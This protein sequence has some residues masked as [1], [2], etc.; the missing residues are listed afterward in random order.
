MQSTN[1]Q[2]T[3]NPPIPSILQRVV[4]IK[5]VTWNKDSHGLFDYENNYYEMKKF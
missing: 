5:S 3:T 1:N 4:E 2:N